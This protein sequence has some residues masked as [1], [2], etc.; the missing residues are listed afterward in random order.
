MSA[1]PP[2]A[3]ENFQRLALYMARHDITRRRTPSPPNKS[4][5]RKGFK[6]VILI[7]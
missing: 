2:K 7:D 1:L 6:V 3:G 5:I 4:H